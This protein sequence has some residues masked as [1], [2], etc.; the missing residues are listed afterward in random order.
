MGKSYS[1]EYS[2][3]EDKTIIVFKK[4]IG[5][6]RFSV[7]DSLK[8]IELGNAVSRDERMSIYEK[9]QKFR[10][11]TLSVPPQVPLSILV[12]RFVGNWYNLKLKLRMHPDERILLDGYS[13]KISLINRSKNY[14]TIYVQTPTSE[15]HPSIHQLISEFEEYY[16]TNGK[17]PF[18]R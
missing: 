3:H 18:I 4:G 7:E 5:F 12:N 9:Y 16:R 17:D 11:D 6:S 8:V 14:G 2:K 15:S 10:R 1:I 13:A